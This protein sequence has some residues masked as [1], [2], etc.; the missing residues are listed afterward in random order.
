[1][2][3][4]FGKFNP[5]PFGKKP[6]SPQ[7]RDGDRIIMRAGQ[8]EIIRQAQLS[9]DLHAIG[10]AISMLLG[11]ATGVLAL[12]ERLPEAGATAAAAGIVTYSAQSHKEAQEK[13]EDLLK[14][15]RDEGG[16]G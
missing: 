4:R 11:L 5:N 9:F 12:T 3:N 7:D 6:L 10:I 8:R 16:K 14:S 13:L 2:S 15:L 1:M